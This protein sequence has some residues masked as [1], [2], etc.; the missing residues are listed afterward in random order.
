M[1]F[2][3]IKRNYINS[4]PTGEAAVSRSL[5]D[6]VKFECV[7]KTSPKT[8]K[9]VWSI[10]LTYKHREANFV[11]VSAKKPTIENFLKKVIVMANQARSNSFKDWCTLNSLTPDK[12]A[13]EMYKNYQK[14]A[15]VIISLFQDDIDQ[16]LEEI[17][18]DGY[19][20]LEDN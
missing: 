6:Q 10:T 3:D 20:Y 5:L 8:D 14:K 12:A 2:K 9:S 4:D 7:K 13:R 11:V 17:E 15:D 18:R 19:A 16:I 1:N